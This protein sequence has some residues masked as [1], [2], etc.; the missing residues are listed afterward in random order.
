MQW[1]SETAT[2]ASN[3]VGNIRL[4]VLQTYR[5]ILLI[6]EAEGKKKLRSNRIKFYSRSIIFVGIS[7]IEAIIKLRR[8]EE[9]N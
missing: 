3:V 4:L 2:I 5:R 9:N 6:D 1:T 8:R 7:V